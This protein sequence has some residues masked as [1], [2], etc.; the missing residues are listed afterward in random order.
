MQKIFK[1]PNRE[2]GA[3]FVW[4]ENLI[5]SQEKKEYFS[6][7]EGWEVIQRVLEWYCQEFRPL[8]KLIVA[9]LDKRGLVLMDSENGELYN[10]KFKE[11]RFIEETRVLHFTGFTAHL[12]HV[13]NKT[14]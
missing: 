3:A 11:W 10:I 5:V 14:R 2:K 4:P 6:S 7:L 8:S 9:N 1:I 12:M 13:P